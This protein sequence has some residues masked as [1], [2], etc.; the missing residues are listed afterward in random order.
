MPAAGHLCQF[1][2]IGD[3]ST[4]ITL[5]KLNNGAAMARPTDTDTESAKRQREGVRE[6]DARREREG[7]KGERTQASSKCNAVPCRAAQFL[8]PGNGQKW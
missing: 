2:T 7:E 5:V 8:A 3:G 4:E 6:R 1:V